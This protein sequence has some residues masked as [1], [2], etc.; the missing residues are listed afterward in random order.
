[1][2]CSMSMQTQENTLVYK[3]LSE[4]VSLLQSMFF[5]NGSSAR[6][7]TVAC[8]NRYRNKYKQSIWTCLNKQRDM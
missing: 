2:V 3:Y 7:K 6:R 1:M 4:Y 8:E 5:F